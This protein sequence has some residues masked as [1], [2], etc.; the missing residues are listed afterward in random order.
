MIELYNSP[1]P[2]NALVKVD[3]RWFL[4]FK[5]DGI[6]RRVALA[7]SDEETA[8]RLRDASHAKLLSSGAAVMPVRKAGRPRIAPPGHTGDLPPHVTYRHPWHAEVEGK[9]LGFFATMDE[10]EARV[11]GHLGNASVQASEG[12]PDTYCSPS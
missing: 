3:G 2:N 4:R 5:E 8:R 12:L 1:K 9:S 11:R 6:Q 10:A 7:T